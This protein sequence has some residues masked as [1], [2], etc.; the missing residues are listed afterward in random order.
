MQTKWVFVSE[1]LKNIY[2]DLGMTNNKT[3]KVIMSGSNKDV[4]EIIK[5]SF[6]TTKLIL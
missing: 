2:T 4:L 3:K 1:W 5:T 6:I